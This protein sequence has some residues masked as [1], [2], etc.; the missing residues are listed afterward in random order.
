MNYKCLIVDDEYPALALL[1]DY[2]HKVP[3]LELVGKCENATET[4][5]ALQAQEI[6]LLFL[7]I[8]MP[9][10]TGVELLRSLHHAPQVIFTTAY[11][12]YALEG[13]ALDV[14][15]YLLKPF[16]FER[17]LKAVNKSIDQ[18]KLKKTA[19]SNQPDTNKDHFFVRA[20]H[21]TMKIN[22]ADILYVEGLR[23][24]VSIY[25]KEKRIITL[26][27]MKKMELIL[28]TNQFM[29]VHKSY[30]VA[31]EKVDALSGNMLEL[32]GKQIP[33]GRMYRDKVEGFFSR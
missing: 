5:A 17:F 19:Q 6:D 25:T 7:D 1:E 12:N 26:E 33:I 9:D 16:S 4:L 23:E 2:I 10:L 31:L 13:F 15:D 32:K 27:A 30:I 3:G 21:K 14:T 18:L 24:Y 22:V 28:P 20:D 11:A 8:Q 29:R